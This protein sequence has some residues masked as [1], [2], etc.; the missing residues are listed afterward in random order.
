LE[1][2]LIV[3]ID[4]FEDPFSGRVKGGRISIPGVKMRQSLKGK[5]NEEKDG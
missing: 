2:L 1:L 4:M 3:N 5:D